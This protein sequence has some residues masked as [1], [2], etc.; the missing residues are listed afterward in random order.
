MPC[1]MI[2]FVEAAWS[3]YRANFMDVVKQW[4]NENAYACQFD[5]YRSR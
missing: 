5:G 4:F 3:S 1:L 2:M